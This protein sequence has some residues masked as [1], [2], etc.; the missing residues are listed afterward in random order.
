MGSSAL[1]TGLGTCPQ[2]VLG[3]TFSPGESVAHL[4]AC[5]MAHLLGCGR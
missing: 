5:F 3:E 1:V 2:G 4:Q